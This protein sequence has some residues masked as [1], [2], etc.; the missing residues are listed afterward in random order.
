MGKTTGQKEKEP[1]PREAYVKPPGSK[2]AGQRSDGPTESHL[3]DPPC[4]KK[5]SQRELVQDGQKRPPSPGTAGGAACPGRPEEL[6]PLTGLEEPPAQKNTP[7]ELPPQKPR[8][9][10][11]TRVWV[12]K[13]P[14]DHLAGGI[15]PKE[16]VGIICRGSCTPRYPGGKLP[17][18]GK[19]PGKGTTLPKDTLGERQPP[20]KGP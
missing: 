13:C 17:C 6:P 5:P 15:P 18:P 11:E 2:R 8:A 16:L 19:G 4:Q 14:N 12:R 10:G 1:A 9:E 3:T 20:M 7:G